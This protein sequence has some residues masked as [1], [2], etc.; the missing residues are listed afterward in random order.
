MAKNVL[1][2]GLGSLISPRAGA[3]A[4]PA[5]A[6]T[7]AIL[8]IQPGER[9]LQVALDDVVPSPLQ[10]RKE[11]RED[12][13]AELTESIREQGIIQPLIA[14]KVEGRYELIAGERRWRAARG[15]GLAKVP[16]IVRPASDQQVIELALI[17]N[18]QRQDLSPIEEARAYQRLSGEFSLR[19][20][21]IA[22]K[23]G[24]SRASV[25]N[26]M[27]LLDLD[28]AV[29]NWLVQGR[30][31]VGHAKVLLGVKAADEQLVLAEKVLR[32]SLTVRQTERLVAEHQDAGLR[33]AADNDGTRPGAGAATPIKGAGG[34]SSPHIQRLQERLRDHLQTH[35]SIRPGEKKGVL[36][37]EYYGTI[38]LARLFDAMGVPEAED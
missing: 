27:R 32:S 37:I 3:G 18:L 20:E 25:A 19:Q 17:E 22:K 38:D 12:Q 28:Q 23:V 35:V 8:P 2:R 5:L 36:E 14:R 13:L 24:R 11:F 10:P 29:Q 33:G 1:G 16:V 4:A 21:D 15:V 9:V 34:A 6:P 26:S 30:L 7:P 31:T